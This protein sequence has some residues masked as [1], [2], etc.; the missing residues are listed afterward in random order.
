MLYHLE[1]HPDAPVYP[2]GRW[3]SLFVINSWCCNIC[4]GCDDCINRSEHWPCFHVFI[5]TP[6]SRQWTYAFEKPSQMQRVVD[7]GYLQ[8]F[9]LDHHALTYCPK[10]RTVVH[11]VTICTKSGLSVL[12]KLFW[13]SIS[14]PRYSKVRIF[15]RCDSTVSQWVITRTFI[16][17]DQ[18]EFSHH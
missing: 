7:E 8:F 14:R 4:I 6:T 18:C 17:K 15:Y 10:D 16:F 13:I 12:K 5:G 9:S 2:Q 11:A 1:G 3:F